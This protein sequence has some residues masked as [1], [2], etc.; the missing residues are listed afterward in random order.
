MS[1]ERVLIKYR[2][3]NLLLTHNQIAELYEASRCIL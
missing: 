1:E 2:G 3:S